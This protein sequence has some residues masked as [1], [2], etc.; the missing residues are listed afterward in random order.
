MV[1]V[2]ALATVF[3]GAVLLLAP[4]AGAAVTAIV[5]RAGPLTALMA[6]VTLLLG[7]W[8]AWVGWLK[9]A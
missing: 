3:R 2:L 8:L 9:R 4:E 5:V 7:G 1:S 6:A